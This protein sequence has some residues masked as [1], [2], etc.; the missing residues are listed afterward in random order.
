[1]TEIKRNPTSV[2]FRVGFAFGSRS[3]C[4]RAGVLSAAL[5][6]PVSLLAV[7]NVLAVPEAEAH[8]V[9]ALPA[10]PVLGFVS[11]VHVRV[12]PVPVPAGAEGRDSRG[13]NRGLFG[14][15]KFLWVAGGVKPLWAASWGEL[16]WVWRA[17]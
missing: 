17:G 2:S 11:A 14:G 3:A 4:G 16:L 6:M 5:A 15:V 8:T 10:V 12:V 9:S 1:M 7:P 13:K